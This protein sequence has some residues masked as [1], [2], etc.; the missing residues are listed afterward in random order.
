MHAEWRR[1]VATRTDRLRERAEH[2]DADGSE[3]AHF[4]RYEIEGIEFVTPE[5]ARVLF[6]REAQ[7][8]LGISGEEFLRRW[9]SGEYQPVPDDTEGRKI[10]R[11]SMIISFARREKA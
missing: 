11:M 3:G 10:A 5:E 6:D 9:D 7:R 1:T 8:T 2:L 4:G